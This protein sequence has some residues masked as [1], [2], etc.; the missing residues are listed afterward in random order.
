M[1]TGF[2]SFTDFSKLSNLL[3]QCYYVILSNEPTLLSEKN[4]VDS[5]TAD[6]KDVVREARLKM[7]GKTGGEGEDGS[8]KRRLEQDTTLTSAEVQPQIATTAEVQPQIATSA[9]KISTTSDET[10]KQLTPDEFIK[11]IDKDNR[12]MSKEIFLKLRNNKP[13]VSEEEISPGAYSSSEQPIVDLK[14]SLEEVRTNLSNVVKS[15]DKKGKYLFLFKLDINEN[16]AN[17]NK[18]LFENICSGN[19]VG[20]SDYVMQTGMIS[21]TYYIVKKMMATDKNR[22]ICFVKEIDPETLVEKSSSEIKQIPVEQLR[23]FEVK[24]KTPGLSGIVN[25]MIGHPSISQSIVIPLNPIK[26]INGI[27][28]DL[29]KVNDS[30]RYDSSEIN[31]FLEGIKGYLNA[32]YGENGK[33]LVELITEA[34]TNKTLERLLVIL[35]NKI[36]FDIFGNTDLTVKAASRSDIHTMKKMPTL[37]NDLPQAVYLKIFLKI[38]Y[39]II[40]NKENPVHKRAKI[41]NIRNDE[42]SLFIYD[43]DNSVTEVEKIKIFKNVYAQMMSHN[44]L[45]MESSNFTLKHENLIHFVLKYFE[46]S[47]IGNY[48]GCNEIQNYNAFETDLLTF[49]SMKINELKNKKMEEEQ[50][51]QQYSRGGL[52]KKSSTKK[53]RKKG[54]RKTSKKN[55]RKNK[56]V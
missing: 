24:T 28:I 12:N 27:A 43:E 33:T 8:K 49:L 2:C 15:E 37:E 13:D 52:R 14:Q 32:K 47:E 41:N 21:N 19:T 54:S 5:P 48:S 36:D 22:K 16:N 53:Y 44:D 25:K 35:M 10:V 26:Y 29:D 18:H 50:Y 38:M 30:L 34:M 1:E 4:L 9:E 17:N 20:E 42:C 45:I 39:I 51:N 7:F 55:S 46:N 40:H 56:R 23:Q 6:T 11:L 31:S 3:N